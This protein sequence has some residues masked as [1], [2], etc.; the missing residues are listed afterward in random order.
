MGH[1]TAHHAQNRHIRVLLQAQPPLQLCLVGGLAGEVRRRE[2]L[3]QVR[4]HGGVIPGHV[5][6]VEHAAKLI[7]A[8]AHHAVQP[9]GKVGAFQLRGVGRRHGVHR[10]GAKNRALEQVYVPVHEEGS[11][12]RP[13]VVQAE[14]V[15]Q[16]LQTVAPLILNIVDGKHRADRAVPLLPHA[17]VLEIDGDEG[18]LPVVAVEH[19]GPGAQVGQHPHHR[20]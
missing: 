11:V 13:A 8:K 10:V 6:A 19:V 4:V 14:Q 15:P 9:V 17:V 16:R 1:Q 5:D 3:G 7:V 12:L 20:P 18:G 2:G